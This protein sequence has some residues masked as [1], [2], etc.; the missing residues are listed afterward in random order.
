M[1]GQIK[2]QEILSRL[3]TICYV[4]PQVEE[5]MISFFAKIIPGGP[6]VD[7]T[8]MAKQIFRALF[9]NR[10]RIDVMRTLLQHSRHNRNK[11]PKYDDVLERFGKASSG[12]NKYVHGL[13]WTHES[14][15]TFLQQPT[16]DEMGHRQAKEVTV[17][18]P[19]DYIH[20]LHQLQR[21]VH[22]TL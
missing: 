10:N 15:K 20:E 6:L 4:W 9:S 18:E 16:V 12:R 2:D 19:D 13:W 5:G 3:G 7:T 14:G 8:E 1:S 21:L 11:D 17:K 22:F